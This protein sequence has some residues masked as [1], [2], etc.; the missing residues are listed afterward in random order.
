MEPGFAHLFGVLQKN[1]C[2]AFLHTN[3]ALSGP[4]GLTFSQSLQKISR[5]FR[6]AAAMA[7]RVLSVGQCV[8]DEALVRW[9]LR[10]HFDCQVVAAEG[11][12]DALAQLRRGPIDL[13]L[14]NRKLDS[15]YSDGI[16][17]IRRLKA[18]PK[19]ADMPVMMVTDYA[20]HQDEAVA[21]GALRGFGKSELD[22]SQ[23]LERLSIMLG[24]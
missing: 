22:D 9:F 23:T 5:L 18:D 1:T 10:Q 4:S 15:D 12:E 14:V 3:D 16:D 8:P 19:T 17:V 7:K 11:L 2:V 24:E 13:V 6:P 21:A 20:N